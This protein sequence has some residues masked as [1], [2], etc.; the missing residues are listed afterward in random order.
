MPMFFTTGRRES[1]FTYTLLEGEVMEHG[2]AMVGNTAATVSDAVRL[3]TK[4]GEKKWGDTAVRVLT[5]LGMDEFEAARLVGAAAANA[6]GIGLRF[7]TVFT[8]TPLSGPREYVNFQQV[9]MNP[10]TLSK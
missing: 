8:E 10:K 5:K 2:R 7:E 3:I 1:P 9:R 4:T 6:P